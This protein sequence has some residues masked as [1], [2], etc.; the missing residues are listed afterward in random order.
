MYRLA[1]WR[2]R[3]LLHWYHYS[4]YHM[5]SM[6][7]RIYS[8]CCHYYNMLSYWSYYQ[9]PSA[10][11]EYNHCHSW[12]RLLLMQHRLH[13][14]LCCYLWHNHLHSMHSHH[15]LH[16]LLPMR[17]RIL[18]RNSLHCMPNRFCHLHICNSQPELHYWILAQ[19]KRCLHTW[20]HHRRQLLRCQHHQRLRWLQIYLL[21]SHR[22]RLH[23]LPN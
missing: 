12:C 20:F 15:R 9:L 7:P 10:R 11:L 4:Y 1:K 21:P 13:Y 8:K 23:C 6:Q 18:F 14:H 19:P 3:R 5:H 22:T 17:C 16:F 2:Y